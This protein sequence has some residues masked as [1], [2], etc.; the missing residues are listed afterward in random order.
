MLYDPMVAGGLAF[1]GTFNLR[2]L[3]GSIAA[4]HAIIGYANTLRRLP[5]RIETDKR[6]EFLDI[7]ERQARR[8]LGLVERLLT[9]SRLE[10]GRFVT[11]LSTV[12]LAEVC[13]EVVEGIGLQGQRV[14][15]ELHRDW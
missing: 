11:T 4:L 15:V 6:N 7:I 5:A 13:H 8:L 12:N 3:R 14:R 1:L 9:A 2:E 10:S